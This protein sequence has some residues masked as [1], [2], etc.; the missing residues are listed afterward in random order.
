MVLNSYKTPL[1]PKNPMKLL[2]LAQTSYFSYIF[3]MNVGWDPCCDYTLYHNNKIRCVMGKISK[4]KMCI[5]VTGQTEKTYKVPG[6]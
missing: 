4:Y 1:G 3:N 5:S 6:A 2:F